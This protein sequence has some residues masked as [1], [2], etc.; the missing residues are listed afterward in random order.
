MMVR[1]LLTQL[2]TPATPVRKTG[3]TDATSPQVRLNL[4]IKRLNVEGLGPSEQGIFL[5]AFQARMNALAQD[6][7][8][9][10]LWSRLARKRQA[11]IRRIDG[12]VMPAR[13]DAKGLGERAASAILREILYGPSLE[14]T[15]RVQHLGDKDHA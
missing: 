8:R 12:G 14:A 5:A 2:A 11:P 4:R 13:M 6:A 9:R 3:V 15:G 10:K 7:A 1:P